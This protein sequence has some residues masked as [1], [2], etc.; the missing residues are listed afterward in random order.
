MYSIYIQYIEI[1]NVASKLFGCAHFY[2]SFVVA[3]GLA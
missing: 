2:H 1:F 3:K